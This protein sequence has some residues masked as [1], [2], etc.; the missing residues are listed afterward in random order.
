[1]PYL[2]SIIKKIDDFYRL[3]ETKSGL[4]KLAQTYN[5]GYVSPDEPEEEI[6]QEPVQD[7]EGLYPVVIAKIKELSKEDNE[8]YEDIANQVRFI[9]ELYKKALEINGGY[10][11]VINRIITASAEISSCID[12]SH[13]KIGEN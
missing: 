12:D 4:K 6:D 1:M 11:Q 2:P 10:S 7:K 13:G 8:Q 9:A 5:G 3:T